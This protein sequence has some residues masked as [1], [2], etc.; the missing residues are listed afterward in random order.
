MTFKYVIFFFFNIYFLSFFLSFFFFF[1][2][3]F[4]QVSSIEAE[5]F[6]H[7]NNGIPFYEGW[8]GLLKAFFKPIPTIPNGGYTRGHF[9]EF[10][11]GNVTMRAAP[12]SSKAHYARK[13]PD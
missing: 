6:D 8:D 3:V 13:L 11:E 2:F 1:T 12:S 9:F 7:R 5:F 10:F 4:L